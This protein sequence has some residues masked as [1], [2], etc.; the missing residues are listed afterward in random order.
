MRDEWAGV[1][2]EWALRF[3]CEMDYQLEADNTSTFRQQMSALEGIKVAAVH[4]GLTSRKVLVME[5]VDGERLSES[6]ADD[7]RALCSTLLNCYLI[8][9]LET[10]WL[11]A[12]PHPGNL[13]R[14]PDGKLAILDFGLITEVWEEGECWEKTRWTARALETRLLCVV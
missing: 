9:L 3:F 13:L 6:S 2:D 11:H 12:D 1:L 4:H 5:W 7:T 14:T 10:G 8:Q